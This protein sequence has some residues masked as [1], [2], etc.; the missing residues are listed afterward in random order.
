MAEERKAPET[1]SVGMQTLKDLPENLDTTAKEFLGD[2]G[3]SVQSLGLGAATSI[4]RMLLR[5]GE[6][7]VTG[8]S[9]QEIA[10]RQAKQMAESPGGKLLG[11]VM[12]IAA[13]TG[14]ISTGANALKMGVAATAAAVGAGNAALTASELAA[15]KANL[16]AMEVNPATILSYWNTMQDHWGTLLV[17]AAVPAVFSAL[18]AAA[19]GIRKFV[20]DKLAGKVAAEEAEIMSRNQTVRKAVTQSVAAADPAEATVKATARARSEGIIGDAQKTAQRL[21]DVKKALDRSETIAKDSPLLG[22]ADLADELEQTVGQRPD[23]F[24]KEAIKSLDRLQAAM[25][26]GSLKSKAVDSEILR[27]SLGPG[28]RRFEGLADEAFN[29][30]LAGDVKTIEAMKQTL[31]PRS[32]ATVA[33]AGPV[34]NLIDVLRDPRT[35]ANQAVQLSR[36]LGDQARKANNSEAYMLLKGAHLGTQK[37]YAAT[38]DAVAG[39]GE[40]ALYNAAR[41]DYRFYKNMMKVMDVAPK[42]ATLGDLVGS[43]VGSGVKRAIP[44]MVGGAVAGPVGAAAGAYAAEKAGVD[45][46]TGGRN[47]YMLTKK[48]LERLPAMDTV[49]DMAQMAADFAGATTKGVAAYNFAPSDFFGKYSTVTAA[50]KSIEADPIGYGQKVRDELAEMN[51]D[52]KLADAMVIKQM[53]TI[54]KAQALMPKSS[55]P[56]SLF[57]P[58]ETVSL[59]DQMKFERAMEAH[60]QPIKAFRSKDPVR[61][62]AAVDAHPELAEVFRPYLQPYLENPDKIPY[63]NRA[64]IGTVMGIA[65]VPIQ[66]PK[67]GGTLQTV[68]TANKMQAQQGQ[69]D[70]A[71]QTKAIKNKAGEAAKTRADQVINPKR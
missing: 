69:Q 14:A 22:A 47:T 54:R 38:L 36:D 71:M 3:K 21:Q 55:R 26:N 2:V 39:P 63:K 41:Q 64:L 45:A 42:Q 1:E 56:A 62:K 8:T 32:A 25:E 24:T 35:T 61:M 37:A 29:A 60:F 31:D 12:G 44:S 7:A 49:R 52:P 33:Q 43:T 70:S 4:G 58:R 28:L 10:I 16:D 66:D 68:I 23:V 13:P 19:T 15:E 46:A 53:E 65:G 50:L 51:V 27:A 20:G 9:E 6:S 57:G 40:A 5:K 59:M 11:E 34:Y 67:L 30:A 17:S 48:V 18:P